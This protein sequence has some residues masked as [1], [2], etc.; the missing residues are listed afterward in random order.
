MA[1]SFI[2][3]SEWYKD[4]VETQRRFEAGEIS[5]TRRGLLNVA[6]SVEALYTPVEL[7]MQGMFGALPQGLQDV[8]SDAATEA[9]EYIAST[10]LFQSAAQLAAENPNA[11]EVLGALGTISSII[12]GVG[13]L[14]KATDS[15]TLQR[16]VENAPNELPT[17]YKGGPLGAAMEMAA[18]VPGTIKRAAKE[19]VSPRARASARAGVNQRLRDVVQKNDEISEL[20]SKQSSGQPLTTLEKARVK[21]LE[22]RHQA[23]L[24]K[25]AQTR[26]SF[27]EGQLEQS[28]LFQIQK[29][30]EI[31]DALKTFHSNYS[32][33]DFGKLDKNTMEIGFANRPDVAWVGEGTKNLIMGKIKEVYKAK[34][35]DDF[36]FVIK[37]NNAFTDLTQEARMKTASTT[38]KL[39]FKAKQELAKV[40][41]DK[42]EFRSV[43]ELKDFVALRFVKDRD[44]INKYLT[45][46]KKLQRGEKLTKPQLKVFKEVTDTIREN[47]DKIA[48]VDKKA[49]QIGVTSSHVS[50]AK[51]AGGVMDIF[52]FDTKGN[53]MHSMTD[54]NDLAAIPKT[55]IELEFPKGKKMITMT[56]PYTYNLFGKQMPKADYKPDPIAMRQ[57]IQEKTGVPFQL[58][59]PGRAKQ[60]L[61]RQV[62][63]GIR[64]FRPEPTRQDYIDAAA[65]VAAPTGLLAAGAVAAQDDS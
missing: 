38:G 60:D 30:G 59:G 58:S 2:K 5:D 15:S 27:L 14:K 34:N 43:E 45:Y 57:G 26:G 4:R 55:D 6:G 20:Y 53:V 23:D 8:L 21:A 25:I 42:K 56:E 24:E 54:K 37:K 65:A 12:P 13:T 35:P 47:S 22:A 18:A 52:V 51:A 17:F 1:S 31:P 19:A 9:G 46:S 61:M 29:T 39:M 16:I 63:R 36:Q 7:A 33:S 32:F 11:A 41:P 64:A 50:Q 48:F 28:S 40:M 44:R 49:G 10:D 62:S 3:D